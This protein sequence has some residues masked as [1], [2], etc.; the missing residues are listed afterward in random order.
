MGHDRRSAEAASYRR[1][2]NTA[3]WRCT[4]ADQLAREPLCR[5]CAQ[6][7]RITAATVCNHLIPEQKLSPATFF[8]GPFSSSCAPCHD[9][10]EQKAESAGYSAAAGADGWPTDPRHP[11]NI[12][13]G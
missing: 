4:R 7:G 12:R 11:A 9:S 13:R 8:D 1:L 6:A 5:A 3:Q 10:G 2:Y